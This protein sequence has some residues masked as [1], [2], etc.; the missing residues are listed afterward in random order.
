[1]EAAEE[2]VMVT[3]RAHELADISTVHLV[4]PL[5]QERPT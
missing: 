5:D 4:F 1:M 2:K 3:Y